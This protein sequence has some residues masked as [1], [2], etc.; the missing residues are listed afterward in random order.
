MCTQMDWAWRSFEGKPARCV[1]LVG[2]I[3]DVAMRCKPIYTQNKLVI[4]E[5]LVRSI[6][7]FQGEGMRRL[8]GVEHVSLSDLSHLLARFFLLD[9]FG[10]DKEN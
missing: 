2:G 7:F 10:N 3:F 6:F 8:S 5:H 1:A 4:D 9:D